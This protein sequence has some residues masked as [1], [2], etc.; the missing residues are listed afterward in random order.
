MVVNSTPMIDLDSKQ[1]S[2]L[3]NRDKIFDLLTPES[4]INTILN[5]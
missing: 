5:K 4:P 2:F 1:N 3:V